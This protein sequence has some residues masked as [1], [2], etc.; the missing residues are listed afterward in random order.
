MAR[1]K[2]TGMSPTLGALAAIATAAAWALSSIAFTF[3]SLR[4]GAPAVNRVRLLLAVGWLL[5]A[6]GLVQVPL[7][8]GA[9]RARWLLLG[10]SGF[11]G[12]VFGDGCLFQAFLWIGP[13]LAM[14]LLSTAP[15]LASLGAWWFL[16]E[17]LSAV[18]LAGI[19][20]TLAGVA[21]VVLSR[22]GG[23]GTRG[24]EE[25]YVLG[26][27]CG[28]GGAVGQAGGLLLAKQ[29]ALD[30]FPAL[31]VTLMRM[32]AATAIL[33]LYTAVRGQLQTTVRRVVADRRTVGCTLA[34]SFLGPFL[35]VTLSIV[36]IQHISVGIAS[37]L[38]ALP[39]VF[40]LPLS[41]ALFHER[42]GWKAVLGTGVAMAGVALLC[43]VG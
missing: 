14:L 27:L 37:T 39:P 5:A 40:L 35:G 32:V 19:L 38:M 4:A 28:L 11:V 26:I 33:W 22:E 10:A 21:W 24:P 29:G 6:H 41:A 2:G 1:Q 7:P 25:R 17:A 16:G 34:G 13:R 15:A 9:G 30:G 43:L 12:L 36:A 3:A 18:Q 20:V 42:V 8:W 23:A 31:S